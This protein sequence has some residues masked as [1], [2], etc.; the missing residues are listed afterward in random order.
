[1]MDDSP[2]WTTQIP[3]E[4][5][6]WKIGV[7]LGSGHSASV[8][9]AQM[10]H[11]K[12]ALKI[13]DPDY[14]K[15]QKEALSSRLQRQLSLRDHQHPNIVRIVDAGYDSSS[16]FHFLAMEQ[17]Q[18][19]DLSC[20]IATFNED[21]IPTLASQIASAAQF[22]ESAGYAHRDI[23]PS[24]VAWNP[25]SKSATLLDF[26]VVKAFSGSRADDTSPN[27]FIG[28]TR[29]SPPEFITRREENSTESWRAVTFY[30]IGAVI[31][32]VS[33]HQRIFSYKEEPI[34][35]LHEAILQGD[36][37]WTKVSINRN[38]VHL[39]KNCLVSDPK[40]RLQLVTWESFQRLRKQQ[41]SLADL[42][43]RIAASRLRSR[44]SLP[45]NQTTN[46]PVRLKQTL[47]RIETIVREYTVPRPI[48]PRIRTNK[49]H[50]LEMLSGRVT[51]VF[52]AN[53]EERVPMI[54]L[55]FLVTMVEGFT[56][57]QIQPDSSIDEFIT[58]WRGESPDWA[59]IAE[60]VEQQ[61]AAT[62]LDNIDS[63]EL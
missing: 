62:Y 52:D 28:S 54:E 46:A 29:Y 33:Q 32:E 18:G 22:L 34:A 19:Q 3:S 60:T 63:S 47:D 24:N 5:A 45:T 31:Y 35:A 57:I 20:Q 53:V 13:F 10:G 37:R 49:T 59:L 50:D 56:N 17:I 8:F 43:G 41:P 2:K 55:S 44:R 15:R 6:G 25:I 23:K 11:K 26:G 38:I 14:S 7:Y 4:I 58:V 36:I 61:I 48:Y 9:E 30:Q 21:D 42:E 51:I 40:T 12:C 1:M 27:E 39:A 16:G